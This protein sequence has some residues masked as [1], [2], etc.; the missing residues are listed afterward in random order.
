MA[1]RFAATRQR[2]EQ[3]RGT[4]PGLSKST[5]LP[6]CSQG[7]V[8]L[9]VYRLALRLDSSDVQRFSAL[10]QPISRRFGGSSGV[11]SWP[12]LR[13]REA[14]VGQTR[15]QRLLRIPYSR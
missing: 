1:G 2:F 4:R 3:N 8:M 15:P 11:D 9:P 10:L 12:F 5:E 7:F 13:E 6:H 14:Q